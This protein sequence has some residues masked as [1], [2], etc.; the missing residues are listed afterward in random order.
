MLDN[1]EYIKSVKSVKDIDISGKRVLIRVDFNVPLDEDFNI[2]DDKRIRESLPTIN[3]CIDNGAKSIVLVTH[4]GRPKGE[5]KPE[6]SMKHIVKRVERLLK[7]DVKVIDDFKAQRDEIDS[8]NDSNIALLENIR[9]YEGETKNDETLARELADLCDVYINDAFGTSHRKHSSTYGVAKFK[10]TKVAG[11]L[12]K[13]E[14][15][16]FSKALANATKP[17]LLVVGGAKVS[18]KLTLLKNILNVVDKIVIGGA[19]SNTFLK[20]LGHNVQKSLVED[21]LLYDALQIVDSAKHKGVKI[22]LPVDVVATDSIDEQK[23]IK[24]CPIQDIPEDYMAVDIGAATLRLFKEVVSDSQ[25]IV[26]NGPMGI[27]EIDKFSRGTFR[28]AH[29]ISDS[30]AFSLVGGGDTADAVERAGESDNMSF[31]STGGGA[32]LELLEGKILPAFEVLDKS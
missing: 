11:L 23:N 18:S 13:K 10:E 30:Y 19:M 7:R 8:L 22:Y 29:Y 27:Y 3:Y 4:L 17:V 24:V 9:Y 16:A 25:T 20:A 28:L 1:I 6:F 15:D 14:I 31:I 12:L 21:D 2:S 5:R 26:W 32:S